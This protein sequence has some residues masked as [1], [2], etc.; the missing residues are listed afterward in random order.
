[1]GLVN[2]P[3]AICDEPASW[4]ERGGELMWSALTTALGKPNSPLKII[5]IG[6]LAPAVDGWWHRLIA[7]GST[8]TTYVQA[9]KGDPEKWDHIS[10]LRR[11]N[12]LI[13]VDPRFK[14]RLLEERRRSSE[15]FEV[16]G[17]VHVV[18]VERPNRRRVN[19]AFN[20]FQD[21]KSIEARP[22]PERIGKPIVG[23]D[24]GGGR[25]WSAAVAVWQS[26]RVEALASAPGIPD[27]E[28]QEKR[29]RVAAGT[30]QRLVDQGS[31]RISE[32]SKGADTRR[33]VGRDHRGVGCSRRC[34]LRPFQTPG[35]ARHDTA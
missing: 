20:R 13:D 5:L 23:L 3:F 1:M 33:T 25:A 9:L 7:A 10:E 15:R 27:I 28:S 14:K 24:L 12:P 11:V 18:S 35:T 31:L 32:G 6:T 29:D 19:H 2:T 4:L 21:Y 22:V 17:A 16:T 26:G 30:Y 8:G 34:P